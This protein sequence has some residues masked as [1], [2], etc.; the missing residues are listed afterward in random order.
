MIILR[1]VYSDSVYQ[2]NCDDIAL[3]TRQI[4]KLTENTTRES[5]MTT[6]GQISQQKNRPVSVDFRKPKQTIMTN[7]QMVCACSI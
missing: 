5:K 4:E 6:T 3:I 1:I 7:K 2:H